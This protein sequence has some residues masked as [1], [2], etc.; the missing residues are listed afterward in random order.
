MRDG[1]F[2]I[3]LEF[4]D[5]EPD[6]IRRGQTVRIRLMLGDLS[7]AVMVARGGFYNSTGGNWIFVVD[8]SGSFAT[9]RRISIGTKN[10]QV[11]EVLEGLEEGEE[12]ITSS[13]D[14]FE[15]FDKL[16]FKDR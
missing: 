7:E 5:R 10:T 2:Q 1:R 11:F 9:R 8:E 13:Y 3:D 16:V 6:G 4:A 12:V 14:N 15:D